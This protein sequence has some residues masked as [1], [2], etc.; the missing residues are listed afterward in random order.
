MR[1][2]CDVCGA[3]DPAEIEVAR[4]YMTGPLHVCKACGHIYIV[5][6][7]TGK[8]IADAWSELYKGPYSAV[9]PQVHAQHAYI[10][11]TLHQSFAKGLKD[12]LILDIGSGEWDVEPS[13][14]NCFRSTNPNTFHGTIEEFN[15]GEELFEFVIMNFTLENCGEPLG[16]LEKVNRLLRPGGVVM[17]CTGYRIFAPISRTLD[18]YLSKN[19]PDTHPSRWHGSSLR[20]ILNRTGMPAIDVVNAPDFGLLYAI[21]QKGGPEVRVTP[22]D[23]RE[24]IKYFEHWHNFT[25]RQNAQ[26]AE[27]PKGVS[28]SNEDD[29]T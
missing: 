3:D 1:H 14:E 8:D 21:G 10:G 27:P 13:G 18:L 11:W 17:I 26:G 19:P 25:L 29:S 23:Y 9:S 2:V 24:V 20:M 28:P 6:R 7:R 22:T 4:H 5:E 15:P 16:V 12:R